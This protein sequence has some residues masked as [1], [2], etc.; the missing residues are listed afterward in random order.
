MGER[1]E[2]PFLP[3]GPEIEKLT[4]SHKSVGGGLCAVLKIGNSLLVYALSRTEREED[5]DVFFPSIDEPP[6][7]PLNGVGK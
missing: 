7:L 2:A 6:S 1:G 4:C 5:N 3:N